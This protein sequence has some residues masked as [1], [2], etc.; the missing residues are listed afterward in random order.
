LE[1]LTAAQTLRRR[2]D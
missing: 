1:D 2:K